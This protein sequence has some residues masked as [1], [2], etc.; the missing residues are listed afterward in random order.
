ML[1]AGFSAI[2]QNTNPVTPDD[3]RTHVGYLAGDDMKGRKNGSP[4]MKLAANYIAENF[5]AAG[6]KPAVGDTSWFQEYIITGRNGVQ[7]QERNVLGILEGTDPNLKNEWIILSAHFDHIGIGKPVNGDSIYN[8][9]DDNATGT[10]TL[11]SLA[12]LLSDPA[13]R[14]ARSV[15]FAAWSGEEMGMR[16]SRWF[17]EH[18]L[19][20]MDRMMLNLNF[21]M[22][23]E[24]KTLGDKKFIITGYL[25]TDFDD[26]VEKYN[27]NSDWHVATSMLSSPGVFFA[28]DNA[29]FALKRTA[30][31]TELNLHAYTLVTTDAQ[32]LIHKVTDD[33]TIIDYENMAAFT[34]YAAGL[35]H[36]LSSQKL[37]ISWDTEAFNKYL[38][39]R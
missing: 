20:P 3:L 35:I 31:A 4:E 15:L 6:L 32:G 19:I 16:G 21:E 8:G 38:S 23:G 9:A 10:V 39:T 29:A 36:W 14:P 28:S 5:R 25:F 26:L 7:I 34:N 37:D 17:L 18:P 12:K 13:R 1:I 33:P 2:A 27:E 11:M 22:T 30:D 24:F